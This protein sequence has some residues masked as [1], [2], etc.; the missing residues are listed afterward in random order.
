[1]QSVC[2]AGFVKKLMTF[3][4]INEYGSIFHSQWTL[5]VSLGLVYFS[6]DDP[7]RPYRPPNILV[8]LE[9][10]SCSLSG[11]MVGCDVFIQ[12]CICTYSKCIF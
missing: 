10:G 6:S 12:K 7:L 11:L 8:R 3:Q 1:M 2:L 4:R 5:L 9:V